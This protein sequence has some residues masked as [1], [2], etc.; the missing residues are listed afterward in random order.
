MSITPRER[1]LLR[2][3][4]LCDDG[5]IKRWARGERVQPATETRLT[6]AARRLGIRPPDRERSGSPAEAGV[7][8]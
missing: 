3:E 6:E 1:A 8:A 5:T 7:R 2:A 4:S